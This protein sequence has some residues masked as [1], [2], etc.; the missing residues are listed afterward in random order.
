MKTSITII[1]LA[2]LTLGGFAQ[3]PAPAL[4]IYN[5]NFAVVRDTVPLELKEGVNVAKFAGMTAT[6]E[7]D[8]VVLRDP[9]GKVKLQVHG[10]ELSQRSGITQ[11]LMLSLNEG[12][13]IDFFI[14]EPNKPDTV[15]SGKII[16]SVFSGAGGR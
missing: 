13:T 1:I 10:A 11:E 15:V 6:A 16:R 5:Q 7:T 4:T 9:T 12:K 2:L 14:K 8:S 3:E